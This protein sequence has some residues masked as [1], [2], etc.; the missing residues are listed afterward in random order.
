MSPRT[1]VPLDHKLLIPNIT[2]RQQTVKLS[3][4]AKSTASPHFRSGRLPDL[5]RPSPLCTKRLP[6]KSP[7][8]CAPSRFEES[9]S[10]VLH[11]AQVEH[12]HQLSDAACALQ[13][14]H[15]TYAGQHFEILKFFWTPN[16]KSNLRLRA[17]EP[18]F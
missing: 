11:H 13:L 15:R 7:P 4:G 8:R 16:S 1:N 14:A 18:V 3:R 10:S 12:A 9:A 5:N 2:V 6:L 17:K